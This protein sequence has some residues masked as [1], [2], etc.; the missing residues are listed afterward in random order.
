MS[1]CCQATPGNIYRLWELPLFPPNLCKSQTCG[2]DGTKS[3]AQGGVLLFVPWSPGFTEHKQ[4]SIPIPS[5]NCSCRQSRAENLGLGCA[6]RAPAAGLSCVCRGDRAHRARAAPQPGTGRNG[7]KWGEM[8][9]FPSQGAQNAVSGGWMSLSPA[10][11][12]QQLP[13][14]LWNLLEAGTG[15]LL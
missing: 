10:S 13:Q 6:L 11:A 7:E 3:K 9:G 8:G 2:F 12:A 15:T 1:C 4:N 14:V 5:A